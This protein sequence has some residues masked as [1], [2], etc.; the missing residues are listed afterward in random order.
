MKTLATAIALSLIS[1]VSFANTAA[2]TFIDG[3]A[4]ELANNTFKSTKTR[5]EVIAELKAAPKLPR[6]VDGSGYELAQAMFMSTRSR[7]EVR[8]EAL[9]AGLSN[10]DFEDRLL[11]LGGRN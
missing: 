2:P 6:Y 3:S 8:A 7:A 5:A 11:Q 9:M 4:Y 10:F 1:A